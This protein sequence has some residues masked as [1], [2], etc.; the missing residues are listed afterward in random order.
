M[1]IRLIQIGT[2]GRLSMAPDKKTAWLQR[3]ASLPKAATEVL[4]DE[5]S[6]LH[7]SAVHVTV[8]RGAV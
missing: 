5:L 4:E 2:L 7:P 8:G 6:P 3:G 1:S